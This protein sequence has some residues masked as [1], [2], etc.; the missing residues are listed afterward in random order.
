[1]TALP[2]QPLPI[3][4]AIDPAADFDRLEER[5]RHQGLSLQCRCAS[6]AAALEQALTE[7]GWSLLIYDDRFPGTLAHLHRALAGLPVI[8]ICGNIGEKRAVELLHEEGVYDL[9]LR[10]DPDRLI[11]VIRR[12]LRE[13]AQAT[14]RRAVEQALRESEE[15]Y[16]ALVETSFDWIWEVD[17]QA[18]YTYVSARCQE[19]LGYTPA[20]IC[21]RTPFD[22][23]PPDEADRV[24][25]I[26]ADIVAQRRSFA[27]LTNVCLAKDGR[28]VVLE[29]S[30]VPILGP[31]GDCLGYRGT[32]RDISAYHEAESRLRLQGAALE[33]V[34]T[35]VAIVDRCGS[36]QWTNAAFSAITGYSAP[37]SLGRPLAELLRSELQDPAFYP[38]LWQ[39]L[40]EGHAWHG[41]LTSRRKDGSV[42][43]EEMSVT[44]VRDPDGE[45]RRFVAI[46]QDIGARKEGERILREREMQYRAIIETSLDGFLILDTQ[47][48]ILEVNDAYVHRSG[49]S[50]DALLQMNLHGL[51]AYAD[52]HVADERI[53]R[54]IAAG[55][56]R[57][58]SVHRTHDGQPWPV[59]VTVSYWP[60]AG[61]RLF[62]FLRDVTEERRAQAEL[63]QYRHRLEE[64]VQTRTAELQAAEEQT[65]LIVES[66]ADGLLGV[67]PAGRCTFVN[68]SASRMLGYRPDELIGRS[69]H[70]LIH[71]RYPDG[72][73][74]PRERCPLRSTLEE[75]RV[76]RR[77]DEV[78]WRSDGRPVAVIYASHP[79]SRGGRIVGAVINFSDIGA[80]R[81]AEAARDRAL[82]EAER[83]AQVKSEFLANMSHEIRT[84]LNAVLG[85]AQL[86]LS[87]GPGG[88]TCE[89]F[90]GILDSGQLLLGIVDDILDFSKLEAGQ[91]SL[92]EIP[93]DLGAVID[94]AVNLTAPRAFAKSIGFRVEEA[95]DLP[96]RCHGDALRISQVLVNLLSNAVKFTERGGVVVHISREGEMLCFR[97]E[98][99]G[100][101]MDRTQ[102][103]GLFVPF[104]QA[105]GSTT[106]RFGGTGLGLAI[107]RRL[108]RMMGGNIE[109]AS[110][111]G[112]GSVFV[113]RL[114]LHAAE[115]LERA[116]GARAVLAGLHAL[117]SQRLAADLEARGLTVQVVAPERAFETPADVLVLGSEL[118]S[119]RT[120]LRRALDAGCAIAAVCPSATDPLP[121][122]LA[123]GELRVLE[124]PLRARHLVAMARR[125]P[126]PRTLA[127]SAGPRLQG[128]RVLAAEDNEINRLVLED[129]LRAE[130]AFLVGVA[131]GREAV[132]RVRQDGAGFWDL[133]LMDIQMPQM[134][135]YEATACLRALDPE[136]PVVGLTAHA[137]QEE[138]ERCLAAGMAGHLAKPYELARLVDTI[139]TT[140]RRHAGPAV[141]LP[142]SGS[143]PAPERQP[144]ADAS[145]GA[146]VDWAALEARFPS[147]AAFVDRL[148]QRVVE[149]HGEAPQ[150]LRELAA[151]HDDRE[152]V[153][154]AHG[155][156][157]MFANLLAEDLHTLALALETAA[158]AGE[159]G[160]DR[161]AEELA[162]GTERFLAALAARLERP[163]PGPPVA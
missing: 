49:Y 6:D 24:R 119:E 100:I 159:P 101:G 118:L 117:E 76:V 37:E 124:R 143:A 95:A 154:L 140:T 120:A 137:M 25:Q 33:A 146:R 31:Q 9:V 13:A 84:P 147:G 68:P 138:R 90:S 54:T 126:P 149:G 150:R 26:F 109:V 67:D 93:I 55:S 108:A 141:A 73:P 121:S 30:G 94:R 161:L 148:A 83:L 56:A 88:R 110:R 151:A 16:R 134:D 131:D 130:G 158:R 35:A 153:A 115:G 145:L 156:K 21:G 57:F 7:G 41:E 142:Q 53:A 27:R 133:V 75:N 36:V 128:I 139:L 89:R 87:E 71:N 2:Q 129:L 64:L 28:R 40:L 103:A 20:E 127:V 5:L 79:M 48:R 122:V 106:R 107:S 70:D 74:Y 102:I 3:L 60:I 144:S 8:L 58:D 1:M 59:E 12:C 50:R 86:G 10:D 46:K 81:A 11:S 66:T 4:V 52:T 123:R 125:D 113:L 99:T 19:F 91:L 62:A 78:F 132:E 42:Y 47:G 45:I 92:E 22:L 72:R 111:L 29:T 39:S 44:P 98:D 34:A 38:Q 160:L 163:E 17:A 69:V 114:P 82:A 43:H 135:G 80:R 23:M 65:R 105:D 162:A 104:Q 18:R 112:E 77:E 136:L 85:L 157:G 32:D 97:V 116:D 63:E 96:S 61:G 14:A 155:L 15:R 51:L 152:L